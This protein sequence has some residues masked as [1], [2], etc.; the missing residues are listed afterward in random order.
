MAEDS[1]K[2]WLCLVV[3]G[4]HCLPKTTTHLMCDNKE[5]DV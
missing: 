5:F 4:K 3:P 2:T 1:F